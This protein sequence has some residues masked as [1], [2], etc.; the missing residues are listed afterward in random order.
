MPIDRIDDKGIEKDGSNG[1]IYC[2]YCYLEGTFIEP[3]LN[4]EQMKAGTTEK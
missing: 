1:N 3:F 2:K 4:L